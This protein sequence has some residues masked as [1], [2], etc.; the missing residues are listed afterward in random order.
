MNRKLYKLEMAYLAAVKGCFIKKKISTESLHLLFFTGGDLS[1]SQNLKRLAEENPHARNILLY[2]AEIADQKHEILTT[3]D[4][5]LKILNIVDQ[6][7]SEIEQQLVK[8][9]EG[10]QSHFPITY[11]PKNLLFHSNVGGI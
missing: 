8:Q 6:V 7:L 2:K 1:S 11:L 4:K 3:E 9:T 10:R 5:Y